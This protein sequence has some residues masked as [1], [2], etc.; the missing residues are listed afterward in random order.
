MRNSPVLHILRIAAIVLLFI[1][2]LNALA[3]GYSFISDPSGK[4]I[5][6]STDYL[7]SSAPFR[8]YFIPGLV[9]FTVIGILSST[10]AVMAITRQ[11]H[12]PLLILLQGC[13]LVGWISIQLTMVTA[14]HPLHAIIASTGVVLVVIGWVLQKSR[15]STNTVLTQKG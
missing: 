1:V 2:S 9:L 6:I 10:V 5:G 13:I 7:R 14:F 15:A 4:S 8:D 11:A 3:A 12:Y